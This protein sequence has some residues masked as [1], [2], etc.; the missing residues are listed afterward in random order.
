MIRTRSAQRILSRTRFSLGFLA[1]GSAAAMMMCSGCVHYVNWP[2]VEGQTSFANPNINGVDDIIT[3][4]MG[5]VV[6]RF[7]PA[8]YDGEVALNLPEQM[9][10][11][12]QE[13][14]AMQASDRTV[15]LTPEH[16]HLPIYHFKSVRTNG[17]RAEV[18]VLRPVLEAGPA[19]TGEPLYQGYTL[20]L[21]GSFHDWRVD[22][23]REWSVGTLTTPPLAFVEMPEG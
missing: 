6:S 9:S 22:R 10:P 5:W 2:P 18:E 12:M 14:V 13:H 4:S 21:R 19:S 15:V 20:Y 3:V 11:T 16:S 23:W 8:G 1:V 7:P 17:T